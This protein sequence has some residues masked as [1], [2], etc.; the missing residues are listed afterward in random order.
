VAGLEAV[1]R[2][3]DS[4][5]D[6]WASWLRYLRE[7]F[8][9]FADRNANIFLVFLKL[10][11]GS[12]ASSDVLSRLAAVLA[13]WADLRE[14]ER[15]SPWH[16]TGAAEIGG[17]TP[18]GEWIKSR[19]GYRAIADGRHDR[20]TGVGPSENDLRE[21]GIEH[22]YIL[23][24]P[25]LLAWLRKTFGEFC[26]VCPYP[27]ADFDSLTMPWPEQYKLIYCNPPFLSKQDRNGQSINIWVRKC[28]EEAKRGKKVLLVL[29][30]L[31]SHNL[32]LEAY[33]SP[34]KTGS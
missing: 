33:P 16:P 23:T 12:D 22:G 6:D 20:L 18:T 2:L 5:G 11:N 1:A 28:I 19:H 27:R 13:E 8:G 14:T 32:L 30:T 29:P 26:D 4:R 21:N 34:G 17:T 7:T 31:P 9:I 10:V 25:E 15:P 24:P 3:Y